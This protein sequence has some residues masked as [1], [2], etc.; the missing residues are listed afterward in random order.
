MI[1][2]AGMLY[3]IMS[4]LVYTN[5]YKYRKLNLFSLVVMEHSKIQQVCSNF[6]PKVNNIKFHFKVQNLSLLN[7]SIANIITD[8]LENNFVGKQLKIKWNFIVYKH[9]FSWII[10]F[11]C[12]FIN[13]TKVKNYS[14]ISQAIQEFCIDFKYNRWDITSGI[15]IDN[16]TSSGSFKCKINLYK[17]YEIIV[18]KQNYQSVKYNHEHFPGLYL[19]TYNKGTIIVFTSGK[20]SIVGSKCTRDAEEVFNTM[21]LYLKSV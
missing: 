2:I 7:N 14:D 11:E 12:G 1:Y 17:L 16:T 18:E 4:Q 13:C 20:Y 10:F 6:G 21:R 15:I 19:K 8:K 3:F 9:V 5:Y